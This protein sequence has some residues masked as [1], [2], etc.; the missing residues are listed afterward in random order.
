MSLFARAAFVLL[1]VASF[2]AFFVA[3]RLKSAPQI[4]RI[5]GL[6][7][8]FSPNGDGSQDRARIRL[9]IAR[10][11]DVTVT[12]VDGTGTEIRRI[13]TDLQVREDV[14]VTVEWDGA[15]DAGT[16]VPDGFYNVRV[17]L[18]SGGRAATPY[19]RLSVDT[20]G[21]AAHGGGRR[22]LDHR[23]GRG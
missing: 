23:A 13:A 14:P 5:T 12:I 22:P 2:A 21:A 19:P 17:S 20:P 11:D 7:Q 6:T 9:K 15:D 16:T 10:S 8:H 1:V 3:Q 18:R 4:A